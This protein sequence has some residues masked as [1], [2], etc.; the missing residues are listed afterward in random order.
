MRKRYSLNR[1]CAVSISLTES[2]RAALE[3]YARG[4]KIS[5]S[6]AL[7]EI[8][9]LDER[10]AAIGGGTAGEGSPAAAAAEP[11]RAK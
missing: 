11:P 8:T 7:R 10:L 9:H 5:L 3:Q 1:T 4:R 6:Q 2:E